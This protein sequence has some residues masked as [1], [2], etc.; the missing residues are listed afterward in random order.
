MLDFDTDQILWTDIGVGGFPRWNNAAN[1][2]SG[3]S[4]IL[5]AMT[6]LATPDLRTLFELH[7]QARG[8]LVDSPEQADTV[9]SMSE[10]ITPFD[11]DRIRAEFL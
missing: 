8:E 3:I 6:A 10:G 5:R 4:L 7:A 11:A 9:F 1:H 2:L